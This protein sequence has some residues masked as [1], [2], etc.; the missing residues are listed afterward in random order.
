MSVSIDLLPPEVHAGREQ[1]RNL[2]ALAGVLA[3]LVATLALV[4][5]N[6]LRRV[7]VAEAA[8][9][10]AEAELAQLRAQEAALGEFGQVETALETARLQLATVLGDEVGLAGI[11]QDLA[12]VIPSDAAFDNVTI[13]TQAGDDVALIQLSGETRQGVAP[14]VERLL[15]SLDKVDAF[16]R[17]QLSATAADGEYTAFDLV[18]QVGPPALTGRYVDGLPEELR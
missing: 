8:R 11:L 18:V 17:T 1:R 16:V 9:E 14:G 3:L 15:V 5:V 6:Q 10:V 13:D 4:Q 7:D 12:A 2:Q